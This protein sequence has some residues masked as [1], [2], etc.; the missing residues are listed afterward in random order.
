MFGLSCECEEYFQKAFSNPCAQLLRVHVHMCDRAGSLPHSCH[1]ALAGPHEL[2][3]S[4]RDLSGFFF[5]CVSHQ[6]SSSLG[7]ALL[8]PAFFFLFCRQVG[9][10]D[11]PG[12]GQGEQ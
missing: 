4:S 8:A 5:L 1:Q 11:F 6:S 9:R 3:E 10:A 12:S 2:R 7:P